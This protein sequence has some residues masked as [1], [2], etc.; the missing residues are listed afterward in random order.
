MSRF[1]AIATSSLIAIS[2]LPVAAHPQAPGPRSSIV[3]QALIIQAKQKALTT[4]Q[5]NALDSSNGRLAN[6]VVRLRDAR[7]GRIVDRQLTD[8]SGLFAF[9]AID[10][11]SYIVELM[12]SDKSILAASE[13]L[14][15]N[16]GE[17]ESAVVKLPVRIPAF[18]PGATAA[19]MQAAAVGVAAV[20]A[21]IPIS[22]N[23]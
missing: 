6:A 11:G 8:K 20:V 1:V 12:S 3:N 19:I 18:T 5:G 15:V 23:Q 9:K 21:T 14:N 16:L 17:V 13:L 4:I 7:Y 22:P 10:P 2:A